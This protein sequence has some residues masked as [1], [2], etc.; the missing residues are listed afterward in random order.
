MWESEG[1]KVKVA[2]IPFLPPSLLCPSLSPHPHSTAPSPPLSSSLSPPFLPPL[3]SSAPSPLSLS[4]S[5]L[6]PPSSSAWEVRQSR[7]R[8]PQRGPTLRPSRNRQDSSSQSSSQ[9]NWRLFHTSHWIW[10][11]PEICRRGKSPCIVLCLYSTWGFLWVFVRDSCRGRREGGGEGGRTILLAWVSPDY[12]TVKCTAVNKLRLCCHSPH[13]VWSVLIN[14]DVLISKVSWSEVPKC[15]Q[16]FQVIEVSSLND[17][18]LIRTSCDTFS[19]LSMLSLSLSQCS[20]SL[21]PSLPLSLLPR[22]LG[23]WENSLKWLAQRKPASS[24]STR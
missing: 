11:G 3:P 21:P 5:S 23:W 2:N 19:T 10:T 1:W 24:S 7:Y 9:Q 4:F 22:E 12:R 6:P 16:T 13:P 15:T 8:A 14:N 18:L 17:T 20:P